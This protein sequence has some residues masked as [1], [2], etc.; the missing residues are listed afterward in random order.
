MIDRD[1]MVIYY[2]LVLALRCVLQ[3]ICVSPDP[4]DVTT[5]IFASVRVSL[6]ATIYASYPQV[7]SMFL[8]AFIKNTF[9]LSNKLLYSISGQ[10][11]YQDF[12]VLI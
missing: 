3:L 8:V 5:C 2:C 4:G 9:Y 12:T 10:S 1:Y 7:K 11:D 6:D